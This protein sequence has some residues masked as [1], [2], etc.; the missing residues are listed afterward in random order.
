MASH[1]VRRQLPSATVCYDGKYVDAA[2]GSMVLGRAAASSC[3]C[4]LQLA[5]TAQRQ[6]ADQHLASKQLDVRRMPWSAPTC[7]GSVCT[8][9][10]L[11]VVIEPDKGPL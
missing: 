6:Q 8:G 1:K 2:A 3:R 4:Q 7:E 10:G 5:W 11:P 9:V